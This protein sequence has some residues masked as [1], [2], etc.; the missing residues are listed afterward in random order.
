M[1]TVIHDEQI[2]ASIKVL[3]NWDIMS[4]DFFKAFHK[5]FYQKLLS[6]GVHW[7]REHDK[8]RFLYLAKVYPKYFKVEGTNI[9]C[10][11]AQAS[12]YYD[13][14]LKTLPEKHQKLLAELLAAAI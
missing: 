8:V 9:A 2:A 4:P 7:Q 6:E 12:D 1:L 13:A 14:F 11:R 10:T 3:K 5:M